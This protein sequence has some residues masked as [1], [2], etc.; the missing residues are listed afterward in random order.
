MSNGSTRPLGWPTAGVARSTEPV[1][2]LRCV[3]LFLVLTGCAHANGEQRPTVS[4]ALR[5]VS[6]RE[7]F[8]EGVAYAARGDTLRA[9]QYLNAAKQRGYDSEI[10]VAWLVRVYVASGRYRLALLRA[11]SH[12]Q[13]DPGN[14][15]LRFVAANLHEVLGDVDRARLEL[16]RVV[17]WAP[18]VSLPHY[19]LAV[20]YRERLEEARLSRLHFQ[21]YLRLAPGGP[22]AAEARAALA[23]ASKAGRTRA[24]GPR[25]VTLRSRRGER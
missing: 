6:A 22:H 13:R 2:R 23:D 16:E 24:H 25:K 7:L 17:A 18:D 4:D 5:S 9:E 12:L 15:W 3:W 14:C 10:V 20:L 21:E 8:D 1:A 11:E 19:R